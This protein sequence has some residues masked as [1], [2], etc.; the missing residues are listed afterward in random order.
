MARLQI[1]QLPEAAG[2]G[3]PPFVLVVDEY[4][5]RRYILGSGQGDRPEPVSEFEGLAEQIGAKHVLVFQETIEIPAN[6]PLPVGGVPEGPAESAEIIDA[7]ERTR[8][9]L[10]DA[11]LLSWDTTWRALVEEAAERQRT[12]TRLLQQ[13]DTAAA[14]TRLGGG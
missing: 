12:V 10:C 14:T 4:V 6:G 3:R 1:L 7:H 5:P 8:L 11:L 13:I 2:D 9:Q